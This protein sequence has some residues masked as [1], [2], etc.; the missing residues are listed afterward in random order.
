MF[1]G[2][3]NARVEKFS[4]KTLEQ[5]EASD[6]FARLAQFGF[7]DETTGTAAIG[8][9]AQLIIGAMAL[10]VLRVLAPAPRSAAHVPLPAD[11]SGQE[12][13]E[14]IESSLDAFDFEFFPCHDDLL[15]GR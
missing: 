7:L 6:P 15:S 11:A 4:V 10:R 2:Q 9:I 8:R 14:A 1:A 12:R 5:T 3:F 13:L